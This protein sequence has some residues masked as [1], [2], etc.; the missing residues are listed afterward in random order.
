MS[1]LKPV[2]TAA[3]ETDA[4][5]IRSLLANA[6]IQSRISSDNGGGMLQS[7]AFTDG[8]V[9]LVDEGSVGEANVILEE[10]RKGE[11]AISDDE[12]G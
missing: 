4:E 1:A 7:L 8:V 12:G 10:Y 6:G 2:Y 11:T 5:I 9:V 3:S